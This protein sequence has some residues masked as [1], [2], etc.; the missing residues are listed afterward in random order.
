MGEVIPF[1]GEY[2]RTLAAAERIGWD[3]LMEVTARY[4]DGYPDSE[5]VPDIEP[6]SYHN[7]QH[8]MRV[9]DHTRQMAQAT[10]LSEHGTT[11]AV[12]AASAHD[13]V[14]GGHGKSTGENERASA[15]WL[16]ELMRQDGFPEA[17]IRACT[18]A[19]LGTEPLIADGLMI[20]QAARAA[21]YEMEEERLIALSVACAD[22]ADLYQPYG[23]LL[24]L[25]L[26]KEGRDVQDD[27]DI[28][29]LDY[30]QFHKSQLH[31]LYTYQ[32][33]HPAG[34]QLF[35]GLRERVIAHQEAVYSGLKNRQITSWQQLV[36][37]QEVF[38]NSFNHSDHF[39]R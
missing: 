8:T 17:D 13:I 31:L 32:Y 22:M 21:D 38:A 4:G 20:G 24:G 18:R 27:K 1:P 34:E 36:E 2:Q 5:L 11:M 39:E 33:P 15:A 23:P 7:M 30:W 25:D 6:L 37:L 3:A 10:G 9:R 19:I 35:G 12:L 28:S 26:Y 29:L 16:E 14:H